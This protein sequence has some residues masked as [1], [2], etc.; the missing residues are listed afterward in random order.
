MLR[1]NQFSLCYA[2][3]PELITAYEKNL[4]ISFDTFFSGKLID[5]LTPL[6][7]SLSG[8]P[9]QP[10]LTRPA[11]A[12]ALDLVH[13]VLRC[14][15]EEKFR[16]HFF[17]TRVRDLLFKYLIL[18]FADHRAE[19]EPSQNEIESVYKAEQIISTDIKEHIPIPLLSKKVFLNE[20]RLK[21]LFKK[22]FGT[23]PYEY[24]I[25]KRLDKAK[26]LLEAGLSVK[27]VAAQVGYRPSDF[28]T[29]FRRH[30]GYP[31]GILKKRNS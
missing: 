17:D 25:V 7:P 23:G 21:Q 11:D 18:V 9:A 3:N 22:F 26:E 27:E 15:Y 12:G 8:L 30:Y 16:R 20:F 1:Q 31:P 4:H 6:F 19:A 29:A 14:Q 24:L 13:S 28:T 5:E 2:S 10:S